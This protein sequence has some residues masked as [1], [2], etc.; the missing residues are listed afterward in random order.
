MKRT[1]FSLTVALL[2]FISASAFAFGPTDGYKIGDRVAD[3]TVNN[4]D[5]NSYSL[6]SNG[7]KA[8]VIVFWS[9]SCPFVQPYTDRIKA[10][11]NEFSG[12]GIVFWGINSNNTESVENVSEHYKD[13]GYNFPMLKDD[14]NVVADQFAAERTPEVFV[15][16]NANM[17][18][19]YHGRIDDNKD[20]DKVTSNDLQNAL[21][22]FLAGSEIAVKETKAFGCSIKR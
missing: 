10:L 15:I 4:F 2:I 22:Q 14:K 9:T 21:N 11:V 18:L 7:G 8:T 1:S 6:S 17:S 12:Q 13:K 3:F 16:D 20:A 19:I 5:G